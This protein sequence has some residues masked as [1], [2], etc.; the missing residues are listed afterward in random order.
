MSDGNRVLIT[1]G[2]GFIGSHVAD[3]LLARGYRVRVL[4]CLSEQVHGEVSGFPA[5]LDPAV[6]T[7]RGDV[8]D[9]RDVE[10]ALSGVDAVFHFA[11]A[12][13]VGQSMYQIEKYIDI[14]N[15]GT[16]ILLE[17]LVRRPVAKLIVA[18]SMSVYG[19]GL[20]RGSDGQVRTPRPRAIEQL[21][22]G[23]WD[24][25]DPEGRALEPVPTPEDKTP[26]PESIYALSKYDQEMMCLLFGRAYEVPVVALRFFNVYGERQALSNPYTG[27]LAIFAARYLNGK[28][29]LI[30]EDGHQRRD[31]V[32]VRDLAAGCVLALESA[33]ATDQVFNLG[34][35]EAYSILEVA[36]QFGKLLGKQELAPAVSG[37]YRSGDIRNCFADISKARKVLGYRPRITLEAG[38][39][40]LAQWL[41]GRM[42]EDRSEA[43]AAELSRHGL[44]A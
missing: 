40:E 41:E 38:L 33:A 36:R 31:F 15:R 1:G 27:V 14:N 6:E 3:A 2:A 30:F 4:D 21:K 20:Y 16:A 8:R 43:A 24:L 37:N 12:V 42:D 23:R 26:M 28:P 18:S 44:V 10:R 32:H 7:H 5:Y 29:P 11:S 25:L 34:G 35:G 17:S 19:E 39:A 9:R 13:G 22:A